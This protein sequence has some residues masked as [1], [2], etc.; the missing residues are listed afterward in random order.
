MIV[1]M[2]LINMGVLLLHRWSLLSQ[3]DLEVL[4]GQ[5]SIDSGVKRWTG[6]FSVTFIYLFCPKA[7]N[8]Q[9]GWFLST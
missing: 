7:R 4:R 6:T 2:L 8:T 1:L 9:Y 3:S 5:A